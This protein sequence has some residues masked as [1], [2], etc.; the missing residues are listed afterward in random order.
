M[1]ETRP[2]EKQSAGSRP[3]SIRAALVFAAVAI[4][5]SAGAPTCTR[6]DA[7]DEVDLTSIEHGRPTP[8]FDLLPGA[9]TA[10][11]RL[12]LSSLYTTD[13]NEHETCCEIRAGELWKYFHDQGYSSLDRLILYV[14]LGESGNQSPFRLQSLELSIQG[15][16]P[17]SDSKPLARAKGQE[18]GLTISGR[19]GTSARETQLEIPL[20]FDFMHRFSASSGERLT[21]N[22]SYDG[23]PAIRPVLSISARRT[24]FSAPSM[25]ILAAFILFW[26]VV[27]WILRRLTPHKE[28]PAASVIPRPVSPASESK[29]IVPAA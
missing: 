29:N 2:F 6:G 22:V 26:G 24:F 9:L 28:E 14:D 18:E 5:S 23:T 10:G 20:G 11:P 12:D 3:W 27:F 21:V 1:I 8:L 19:R 15:D 16:G 17:G 4:L 13:R 7:V 25:V